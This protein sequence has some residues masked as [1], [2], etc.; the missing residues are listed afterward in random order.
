M[1]PLGLDV[2]GQRVL[3]ATAEVAAYDGAS[4]CFRPG[5]DPDGRTTVVLAP[6]TKVLDD[7][8]YTIVSTA[9]DVRVTG[10]PGPLTL[11]FS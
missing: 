5:L 8:A 4:I 6:G 11:R 7:P 2:A 1:L 3:W 9:D 10:G